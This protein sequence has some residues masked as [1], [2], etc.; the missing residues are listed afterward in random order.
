[1]QNDERLSKSKLLEEGEVVRW[2]SA[3][4][5]YGL[6]DE[7]HKTSTVISLCWAL[8]WG[9]ILIGGYYYTCVSQ[10][11]EIKKGVMIFCA[12]IPAMIAWSPVADR[13]NIKKLLYA[14]TDKKVIVISSEADK[15]C[16][17]SID[18][19]DRV[20][21][22]KT[23]NGNCHVRVASPVFKTSAR[24]LPG[25]AFRGEFDNINNNKIYK[26]LVFYNVSAEDGNTIRGLLKP[27]VEAGQ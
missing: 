4:Q 11:Q 12:A 19:I 8:A 24:K 15:A 5:P 20:R 21:V 7:T 23:V 22:E 2:S 27:L 25:L 13:N 17:M 9:I 1:M 10:N 26:G 16:T 3:P 18:D 14:I 6:F